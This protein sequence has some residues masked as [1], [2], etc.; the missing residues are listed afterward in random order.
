MRV[1]WQCLG[2]KPQLLS[3]QGAI[4]AGG[5]LPSPS[6]SPHTCITHQ[7]RTHVKHRDQTVI[8]APHT[9][10]TPEHMKYIPPFPSHAGIRVYAHMGELSSTAQRGAQPRT[11][12]SRQRRAELGTMREQAQDDSPQPQGEQDSRQA[13]SRI[14]EGFGPLSPLV[15]LCVWWWLC[16]PYFGEGCTRA[17]GCITCVVLGGVLVTSARAVLH[18]VSCIRFPGQAGA[19]FRCRLRSASCRSCWRR[20]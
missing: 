7:P 4:G 9:T 17:R 5:G 8:H 19:A 12:S 20:A 18:P 10:T 14:S 11:R 6:T 3:S 2:W 15:T 13:I 16:V 1:R